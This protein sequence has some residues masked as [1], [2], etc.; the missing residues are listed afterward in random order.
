MRDGESG[1]IPGFAILEEQQTDEVGTIYLRIRLKDYAG[2][3][4]IREV[5]LLPGKGAV[6]VDTVTA[7][8]AGDYAVEAHFRT[9][10][11]LELDGRM[12]RGKR[13][14]PCANE[15]EVRI[16]SLSDASRL[17]I[18]EVPLHLRYS[19]ESDQAIWR[20]R[21]RSDEMV[22][23]AFTAR[24]TPH[25]E[26]GESVRMVH[27]AQACAP[28]GIPLDLVLEGASFFITEGQTHTALK[29]FA[30]NLPARSTWD[31][32]AS[33]KTKGLKLFHDAGAP[34]TALCQLDTGA[35]VVGTKPGALSY[36]SDEGKVRW[37]TKLGGPIHD[38][39]VAE[40]NFM[41]LVAGHGP[42]DL[43]A[44][45]PKGEQQWTS[46]IVRKPSPWPWWE[47]TSPAP[48]Q[49]AG[50]ISNGEAF[51]AIG[52]GDIQLRGFDRHGRERWMQRYNEG[53]PGRVAVAE[54]DGSGTPSIVVGGE[55]LSDQA[56]CRVLTPYGQMVAE[57]PVEGWTSMLTALAFGEAG[58]RHFIGCGANRGK[59]LHLF[60]LKD[61]Q[62]QRRWLKLLGG[63]VNG[64]GIFGAEDRVIVAT[65]QGFLL[66]YD[67]AGRQLWHLLIAQ[68]LK[69]MV[70]KGD[71]VIAVDGNGT[72]IVVNLSGQIENRTFLPSPCSFIAA[73]NDHVY[74]A[75]GA[76]IW[77]YALDT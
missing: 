58:E 34:I 74:F 67:L 76:E 46:R 26:P 29:T 62:W 60:E 73:K 51:F 77:H 2:A 38:I 43:T 14:S 63:Q 12:A 16:T 21:Y 35:I 33:T 40:G 27:L 71:R 19:A 70:K 39:G 36:V 37:H 45:D 25:L 52:C 50:G 10:T 72:V 13:E 5:H 44:F 41:L 66:G 68:G 17:S 54:I 22:L 61:G 9:P 18:E 24:E 65:S 23:M 15:V 47:L 75:C 20:K 48:I 55:I 7:N 59:N 30:I 57:L 49:V 56:T 3:D 8:I 32:S 31:E 6:F 64:I 4:W 42:A 28:K 1:I 53:V 69:H 11:R